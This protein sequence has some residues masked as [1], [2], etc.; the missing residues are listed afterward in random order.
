ML[1]ARFRRDSLRAVAR[2]A[3]CDAVDR[4]IDAKTRRRLQLAMDEWEGSSKRSS[5]GGSVFGGAGGPGWGSLAVSAL[6][7]Q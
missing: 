4:S 5:S 1:Q 2:S 3:A 6:R 7:W